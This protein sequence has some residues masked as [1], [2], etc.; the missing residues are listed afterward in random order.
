MNDDER[1]DRIGEEAAR[2]HGSATYSSEMQFEYAKR[3]QSVDRW[4]GTMVV[5]LAAIAGGGG[6]SKV[7]SVERASIIAILS[8]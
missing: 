6:L 8:G 1:H 2:I 4:V 3:W 5:G 7:I